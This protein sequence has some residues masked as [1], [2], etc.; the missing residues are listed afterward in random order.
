MFVNMDLEIVWFIVHECSS[1]IL[2]IAFEIA[3]EFLRIW[4]CSTLGDGKTVLI[5]CLTSIREWL[6]GFWS[7]CLFKFHV[8]IR[9][10]SF[11]S[12]IFVFQS[13]LVNWTTFQPL[14]WAS[15]TF[16]HSEREKWIFT[17]FTMHSIV[18]L[19][20]LLRWTVASQF[21]TSCVRTKMGE[22]TLHH[23]SIS[24]YWSS[25]FKLLKCIWATY[26]NE[27]VCALLR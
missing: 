1:T 15:K 11:C 12:R 2:C 23:F 4:F 8:T 24:H 7:F 21:L 9:F 20:L 3:Y 16:R 6:I 18:D 27:I 5:T 10:T 19:L 22:N 25:L 26:W 13:K 17:P 14:L